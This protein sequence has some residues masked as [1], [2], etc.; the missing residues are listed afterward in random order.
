M[1]GTYFTGQVWLARCS[2]KYSY[3]TGLEY[4]VK[5]EY[6]NGE[7]G[8]E[9]HRTYDNIIGKLVNV[10]NNPKLWLLKARR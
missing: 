1:R 3:Y 8:K 6:L 10:A 9:L 4:S 2:K 5:C 7:I